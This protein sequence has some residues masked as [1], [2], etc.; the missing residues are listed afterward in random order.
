[1]T[2]DQQILD[3]PHHGPVEHQLPRVAQLRVHGAADVVL[4]ALTTE[5]VAALD[6]YDRLAEYLLTDGAYERLG[7][8]YKLYK[9]P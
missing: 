7:L 6:G 8:L 3:L 4:D 5:G 1:M 2:V 9:L